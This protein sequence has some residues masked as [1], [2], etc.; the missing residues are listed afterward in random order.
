MKKSVKENNSTKQTDK[1]SFVDLHPVSF[2]Y[3]ADGHPWIIKDKYTE[4]FP[5]KQPLLYAKKQQEIFTLLNDTKHATVKARLWSRT[6]MEEEQFDD[7]LMSRLKEAIA[8]RKDINN[9]DNYY[10]IF[11]EADQLPGL[12]VQWL[13][14]GILIQSYCGFWKKKQKTVVPL[15][16]ELLAS[17]LKWVLWQDRDY[18]RSNNLKPL[19]GKVPEELL[20]KEFDLTYKL[21]FNDHYDIG[22]YSDMS[23]IR[24]QFTQEF[25]GKSVLNLYAY[26]GAWST[27]ALSKG[28]KHVTSTDLSQKYL[29]WLTENMS[30]NHLSNYDNLC[31]DTL[32]TL[33]KLGKDKQKFD[34]IICDPPSFSS[35]GHKTM[36]ALK[37]YDQIIPLCAQLMNEGSKLLCFLN[38][39]SINEDKYK[40]TIEHLARKN[41]LSII[42]QV[43]LS[44]DC[45]KL[46]GFPEGN[47]LKGLLL[48]K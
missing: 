21:T 23:A 33:K 19:W 41:Q 7:E 39:H 22:I 6:L 38:T 14:E 10:L 1:K 29:D 46:K 13:K 36:S 24:T 2:K 43:S 5:A 27:Y 32:S 35:D 42:K 44:D 4:K 47:Y 25:E 40:Q 16:R 34:Y 11:G 20:L 8:K 9:R 37:S 26:T 12:F 17:Q 18:E 3:L 45:P 48:T 30:L 31:G 15:L 28:A